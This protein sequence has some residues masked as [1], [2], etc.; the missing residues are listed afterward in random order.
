MTTRRQFT[1]HLN[2]TTVFSFLTKSRKY[3]PSEF[4]R[5]FTDGIFFCFLN[6][7][8]S[9]SVQEASRDAR[10]TRRNSSDRLIY[11]TTVVSPDSSTSS[12]SCVSSKAFLK[13]SSSPW[14]IDERFQSYSY[15]ASFVSQLVWRHDDW[16]CLKVFWI[17]S[18][19]PLRDNNPTS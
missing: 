6:K 1:A 8:S 4:T 18:A 5:D 2:G 17:L 3:S 13:R 19:H 9:F 15:A 14:W 10:S 12:G 16:C 7:V 11:S